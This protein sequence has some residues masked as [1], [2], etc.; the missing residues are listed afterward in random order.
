MNLG[1]I[2]FYQLFLAGI[3]DTVIV[4]RLRKKSLEPQTELLRITTLIATHSSWS[5]LSL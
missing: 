2:T 1:V 4:G 3:I 5:H